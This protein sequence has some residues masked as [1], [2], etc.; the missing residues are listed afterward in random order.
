MGVGIDRSSVIDVDEGGAAVAAG[1]ELGFWMA[2][3]W[4]PR[5][6]GRR[7]EAV[8][9]EYRQWKDC[10]NRSHCSPSCLVDMGTIPR[11]LSVMLHLHS[12]FCHIE[13]A[14]VWAG[15]TKK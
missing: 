9:R 11:S 8:R 12:A 14:I 2:C 3:R 13:S 1:W 10:E 7:Q 4:P 15:Q 5:E 6:E